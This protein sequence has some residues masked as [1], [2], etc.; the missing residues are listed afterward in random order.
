MMKTIA[1]MLTLA[2]AAQLAAAELPAKR[3][4]HPIALVGGTVH[5]V[6]GATLE[7][8]T[9]LFTNGKIS[10]IGQT[11]TLPPGTE[12]I[13]TKGKQI[14]PGL[15]DAHS[16][17]GLTEI[18]SVRGTN[19]LSEV[20]GVN[21]NVRAEVAVNPE[22]DII[23]VTRANGITSALTMPGGGT[24]SGMAAVLS[25]DGWTWE[26]MTLRSHVGLVVHWPSMTINHAWWEQRSEE[27]Q[28]K[29][30]DKAL[31]ELRNA[32]TDAR[33]YLA[34]KASEGAAGVPFHKTDMRW[35]AM[36]GVLDGTIPVLVDAEEVQQIQSAVAWAQ[37]EKVKIVLLGGY[38]AWRVADLLKAND[39]PVLVG[40]I[41]RT[42]WRRWEAYDAPFTLAKNLHD[43]GVRYC[44]TGDGGASNE[45]NLPFHAATAAAYGLPKEE[46]LKAVTL[47][48]AQILGIADRIGSLEVG[49]DAT[50][51][52]T[53]GDPLEIM[54]HV[55]LEFIDGKA[56]PLTT[57]HT[58]LYDKYKEKYHRLGIEHP[59]GKDGGR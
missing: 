46:A 36:K 1:L 50:L 41:H 53:D 47:Y 32:F 11:V 59:T 54:S 48:P 34:A 51:I 52:V 8:A 14:Y 29:S 10:A 19:D 23:P 24:I 42:P 28:K 2:C 16:V 38:D 12:S 27:D 3:Q 55:E 17:I 9:V 21:P 56:I 39:I 33:A 4:D 49:K 18:G 25:L 44:I 31:G 35:E 57:K 6:S 20:G 15:I 40:P 30:R 22:S 26:E 37:Q 13:D 7:G 43:A 45:R 58:R 5:T